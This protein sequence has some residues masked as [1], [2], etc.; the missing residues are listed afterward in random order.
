MQKPAARLNEFGQ[1]VWLDLIGRKLIQSGE[2]LRMSREDGIRGVTANPAIFEK[3]I[4]ETGEYDDELRKLVA[5]G[6][7]PMEIYESLAVADVQSACDVLRPL[8]DK[9]KGADGFVSLEVSPFIAR[10]TPGTVA[11]AKR[12]W[13]AVDRPNLFIKIPAN[14]EGI[15]AIREATAAGISVNI[16][17]IFSV[18]V[19]GQVIDAYLSGLEE[20]VAKGLSISQIHSV[21]SFFVSRVDT[22]VDKLAPKELQGKIAV[23][24]AKEA[25]QL[26]LQT[27]ASPRWKA[28]EAK[29]ATRQ[30][31]LWASTGT[32]NKAYSDVLYVEPLIGRD[33]VNTVPLAT[34]HAFNDHGQVAETITQGVDEARAQLR[35]LAAAGIDLED[36]CRKLTQDG[37]ELFEK[38]LH[39]LLRTFEARAAAQRWAAQSSLNER[40]G[41]RKQEAQAGLEFAGQKKIAPGLW[42][43]E[44]ASRD[45]LGF[46]DGPQFAKDHQ[47]EA[48][49]FAKEAAR[50]FSHCIVMGMGGATLTAA[51]AARILGKREGGLDLRVL[52]SSA[53]D[54]VRAA[55]H[56]LELRKTL[57]LVA[58][59]SGNTA[60]TEAFY[61]YYRSQV[62]DGAHFVAITESG[63]PLQQLAEREGFWRT[64]LSPAA[65]SGRFGALG[66]YGLLPAA[67][68]GLDTG[69]LVAEAQNVALASDGKVPL[70][71][72]LAVRLGA[73]AGG[74][75]K[76]GVDKLTFLLSKN[77]EALGPWIEQLVAESTGKRG[78]GIVPVIGEPHGRKDAYGKDRVFISLSLASEAHD[79]TYLAESG[80]T[81]V[82]W[83]LASPE[84]LFGEFFRWQ[85][86]T[87]VMA[88]TLEVEPF[89]EPDVEASKAQTRALLKDP[90]TASEP[91]L[92]AQGLALFATPDHA[93]VLR[94]ASGTLGAQ[95]AVAP[96]SWIAAHLALCD[97]GD[98]LALIAFLPQ[99]DELRRQLAEVQGAI[100]DAT[101]L[102]CT[103]A[104][105]PDHLHSSGQLHKGGPGHG[106]FLFLTSDGGAELPVPGLPYGFGAL[107]AAQARAD[108]EALQA[109]G[110]RVLRVHVEDGDTRKIIETLH[111][112]VKMLSK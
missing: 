79:M 4:A 5:R 71:E 45:G 110:L 60:E 80:H 54:A 64:F 84:A 107:F 10:D 47:A 43:R 56:G 32:K 52:D 100:R 33:T 7:S 41:R 58:S 109:R 92:R 70:Q 21:A 85:I 26:Y 31:P 59:K 68:L 50:K 57:F 61:K 3:A 44:A 72:N 30:R 15:P 9:L 111:A 81:V 28:L 105:G 76:A 19:Y 65:L 95:A 46:L 20:R 83:K 101:T 2:L 69:K 102:A 22:A 112:A 1:S 90:G 38:A 25:Y 88:L 24:N 108:I 87:V 86:A 27:I 99:A 62:D 49:A 77:L 63:S 97:P 29:G 106:S 78:R 73:I 35:A 89:G 91:S 96:A 39:T 98:Y 18:Q 34:L 36:V 74:L 66:W 13:K 104:F 75:A 94:K 16:T 53:P 42:S 8:F 23:A 12:F 93:Q 103:T 6:K 51:A 11:E 48:A 82:Q 14:P 37:L 55:A 67:L 40:L 17:L